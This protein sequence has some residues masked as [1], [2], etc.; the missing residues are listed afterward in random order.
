MTTTLFIIRHA[1]SHPTAG[2]ENSDWPLSVRGR[3]QAE[4]L[5]PLL[6]LLGIEHLVSSPFARCLRTIAPFAEQASLNIQVCSDLRERYLGIDL[7]GDFLTIWRRSWEDFDFA[8]PGRETSR[9]AQRRFVDAMH[10][11]CQESKGRTLA[12]CAHGNVIGLFLNHLDARN[13]RETAEELTNPDVLRF[14]VEGGSIAWDRTYRLPGL[15][16]LVT[17]P[18][19]TPI[20]D[21]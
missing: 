14:R 2:I 21:G 18:S 10:R 6:L 3:Q 8:L 13:G 12:V 1:Q 16:A 9:D 19:E 4:D 5:A 17:D 7:K 15:A 11:V 20:D